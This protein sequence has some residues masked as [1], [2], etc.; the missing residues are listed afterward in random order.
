MWFASPVGACM[1]DSA[2]KYRV[3]VEIQ[4]SIE[5]FVEYVIGYIASSRKVITLS[6]HFPHT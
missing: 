5:I 2:E 1:N 3:K 6:P 4:N